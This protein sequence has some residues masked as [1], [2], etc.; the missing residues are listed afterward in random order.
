VKRT[1]GRRLRRRTTVA[2]AV[3]L[4]ALTVAGCS[5][6][7]AGAAAVVGDQQVQESEVADDVTALRGEVPAV[8]FDAAAATKAT[9]ERLTRGLLVSTAC[10]REGVVV[11]PSQVDQ[12]LDSSAKS[13][14]SMAELQS[15]LASQYSVPA[16]AVSSYAQTFLEQQ[17]LGKK[18]AP[19]ATDGGQQ[20]VTDYLSALSVQL[21]TRVSP[22]FGTWDPKSLTLGAVPTDLASPASATT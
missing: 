15:Q 20:A 16:A 11:T 6:D 9:V 3:A 10:T 14:A 21:D 22:R 17:A 2:L 7:Q 18:L 4:A 13:A 8:T 1:T 12:Q 19:D 5:V